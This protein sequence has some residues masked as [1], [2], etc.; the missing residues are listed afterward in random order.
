M[1]SYNLETIQEQ[2]LEGLRR[3]PNLRGFFLSEYSAIFG[4]AC[5]TCES[6]LAGYFI[7]FIKFHNMKKVKNETPKFKLKKSLTYVEGI[8]F[9]NQNNITDETAVAMLSQASGH[10]AKFE[11]YPKDWDKMVAALR[12]KK[13]SAT[14]KTTP[15]VKVQEITPETPGEPKQEEQPDPVAD[16]FQKLVEM[17]GIAE[18][19]AEKIV[20]QFGTEPELEAHIAAG[21][22][23]DFSPQAN[24][25]LLANYG[26]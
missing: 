25:A 11:E 3:D 21:K 14:T 8:G 1:A 17:D 9:V 22:D 23:L 18:K 16:Y 10:L 2:G 5:Q 12:K 4:S 26:G 7:N 19:T 20:N 6:K 24:K 15:V 13:A